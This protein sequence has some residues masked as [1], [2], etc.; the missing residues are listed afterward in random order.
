MNTGECHLCG[1][2]AELVDSHILPKFAYNRYVAD[3]SAGGSF[4]DLEKLTVNNK[5]LTRYWFCQKCDNEVLGK[6]EKYAAQLCARIEKEP[7]CDHEYDHRL[8][9]FTIS[10]SWKMAKLY[11]E[12]P[13]TRSVNQILRKPCKRW[14]DQLLAENIDVKPY[15]QHL[16]VIYNRK[17]G[18]HQMLGGEPSLD[19]QIILSQ[20][21]P[22]IIIG[23]LNRA[24]LSLSDLEIWSK[25]EISPNGGIIRPIVGWHVG[26]NITQS[27][28][29]HL[30]GHEAWLGIRVQ[31]KRIKDKW[32][33]QRNSNRDK[34]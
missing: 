21:G 11:M 14:K 25:N 26:D 15:S 16:Y 33:Q 27:L 32:L 8:L 31:Q 24:H 2:Y 28:T 18:F 34:S 22:L 10:V 19:E 9:R 4:L 30:Q 5:Q 13:K 23:L 1:Q 17:A 7:E 6:Y 29:R 20:V 3:H 12:R